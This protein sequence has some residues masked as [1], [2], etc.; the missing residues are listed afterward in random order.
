[1]GAS[2]SDCAHSPCQRKKYGRADLGQ[3]EAIA[4]FPYVELT[5]R[6]G[7]T[8]QGAGY[9]P[10]VFDS[11]LEQLN[12]LVALILHHD[13]SLHSQRIKQYV[14]LSVLLYLLASG[15]VSFLL[16]PHSFFMDDDASVLTSV[17]SLASMEAALK[18][19]YSNFCLVAVSNLFNQARYMKAVVGTYETTNMALIPLQ[20]NLKKNVFAINNHTDCLF[21]YV[22][23]GSFFCMIPDILVHNIVLFMWTSM[24]ISYIGHMSQSSLKT[25]YYVDCGPNSTAV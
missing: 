12:E 2:H 5:G 18:G 15:S 13:Q 10:T 8:C 6:N 25:Q 7:I 1:M 14:L 11:F 20:K 16:L 22:L 19:R 4:Q 23:F 9:I 3:E 24:K 21:T 17:S